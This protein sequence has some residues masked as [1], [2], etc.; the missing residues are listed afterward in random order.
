[1]KW[2][3][4]N[5]EQIMAGTTDIDQQDCYHYNDEQCGCYHS[6][7]DQQDCYHDSYKQID[8]S[9]NY[10]Y[11]DNWHDCYRDKST[12][13]KTVT[14]LIFHHYNYN[15]HQIL[16][17]MKTIIKIILLN[18]TIVIIITSITVIMI[19]TI[20]KTISTITTTRNTT[21]IMILARSTNVTSRAIFFIF[22]QRNVCRVS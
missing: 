6:S 21:V 9:N 16:T 10:C 1:M 17:V 15:Q 18:V 7:A 13:V 22:M 12:T 19:M 2:C 11:D 5:Q 8:C 14:I 3:L 4:C 20:S